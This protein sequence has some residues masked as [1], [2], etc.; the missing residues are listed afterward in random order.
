VDCPACEQP[1]LKKLVSPVAF[2]LKGT[3]WYETDFKKDRKRNVA[4]DDVSDSK[5]AEESDKKTSSDD[6]KKTTSSE[7]NAESKSSKSDS[8]ASSASS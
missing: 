3:G 1:K 7:S 2:R 6:S 8:S 4:N 5:S